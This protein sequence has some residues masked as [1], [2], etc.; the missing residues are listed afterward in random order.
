MYNLIKVI[1]SLYMLTLS[2]SLK[3]VITFDEPNEVE[4]DIKGVK[5]YLLAGTVQSDLCTSGARS[6]PCHKP[7]KVCS[8]GL[9][10]VSARV[11]RM[12]SYARPEWICLLGTRG[13]NCIYTKLTLLRLNHWLIHCTVGTK[14]PLI[15]RENWA[16]LFSRSTLAQCF[17][18]YYWS[19]LLCM[20]AANFYPANQNV[21]L[22]MGGLNFI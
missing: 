3:M 19:A 12:L 10:Q 15:A 13:F 20:S 18:W 14:C 7:S 5:C 8:H 4:L 1:I 9:Y 11:K 2:K 6:S 22:R 21:P 16:V 17:S